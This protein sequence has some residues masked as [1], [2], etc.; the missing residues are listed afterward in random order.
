MNNKPGRTSIERVVARNYFYWESYRRLA[1]SVMGLVLLAVGLLIFIFYQRAT[2]PPPV[3]F[4]TSPDGKPI[5]RL[6][7]ALPLYNEA[8]IISWAEKAILNI[9]SFDF[10]NF[11]R[12][13]QD[14]QIYFTLEGYFDFKNAYQASNNLEAVREKK[15]VVSAEIRGGSKI[16]EQ[17]VKRGGYEWRLEVPVTVTYQNSENEVIKQFGRIHM[18][19]E[20][21][22]LLDHPQGLAVSQLILQAE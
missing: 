15:Q 17:G 14:A 1:F 8:Y 22:S 11:R 10:V 21:A 18:Q 6:S 16:T 3:Y 9:Y 2:F 13:L 5:P 20:R 4:A 12:A 19:I 7:L